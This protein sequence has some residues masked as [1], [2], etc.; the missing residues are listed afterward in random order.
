MKKWL[1]IMTIFTLGFLS[2]Q[3][4]HGSAQ[5]GQSALQQV[6]NYKIYYSEPTTSILKKLRKY[7]LVVI[8]PQLY[9]KEQV[10]YLQE[11]GTIVLGYISVMETPTWNEQRTELLLESD[12]FKRNENKVHYKQWDSYLMDISSE[13]YHQVLMDEMKRQVSSKGMDGVFF[14]TV[15]NIDNE[16]LEHHASIYKKQ[17][18]GLLSFLKKSN[19][20]F[21]DLLM[22][23]N[24][25]METI[26]HTHPYMDGFMWEGF[27]YNEVSTDEWAQVQINKLKK[28]QQMGKTQV[29]TVSTQS[30][31]KSKNYA[32]KFNF[33]HYH[34]KKSYDVF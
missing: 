11:S 9:T 1:L 27:D 24:W 6:K 30:E 26:Q 8:E 31:Q 4:K 15:G 25:G 2:F 12:Y 17:L 16:H 21:P 29:L 13:H 23:Q 3:P 5:S 20:K 19:Q 34:D 18:D 22:V 10:Q 33:L 14:D 7:D 28:I 32:K